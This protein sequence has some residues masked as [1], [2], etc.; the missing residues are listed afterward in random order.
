ML[1]GE[2]L[3]GRLE[4]RLQVI[5]NSRISWWL[6]ACDRLTLDSF[7]FLV[8]G[9]N[10]ERK[11]HPPPANMRKFCIVFLVALFATSALCQYGMPKCHVALHGSS[12]STCGS[13][14]EPCKTLSDCLTSSH[15][16]IYGTIPKIGSILLTISEI[17]G[18]IWN[19]KFQ[20]AISKYSKQCRP[21]N[22]CHF[23]E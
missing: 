12:N 22:L 19:Q 20:F 5:F 13:E 2:C 14:E 10:Q 17:R 9:R 15:L 7:L 11:G 4:I 3:H 21:R 23:H 1:A 8:V 6:T 18:L 16:G